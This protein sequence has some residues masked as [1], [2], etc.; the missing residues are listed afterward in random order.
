MRRVGAAQ[1]ELLRGSVVPDAWVAE[2]DA[3]F[4]SRPAIPP[5]LAFA[6]GLWAGCA[7]A[8]LRARLLSIAVCIAL[9]VGGIATCLCCLYMLLR[10]RRRLLAL[11]LMAGLL[12]GGVLGFAQGVRLHQA[13]QVALGSQGQMHITA[14]SDGV[15]GEFGVSCTAHVQVEGSGRSFTA[16]QSC[17]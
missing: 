7:S 1:G 14:L 13:Q 17:G 12:C 16:E 4:P 6:L 9:C 3:P 10:R 2:D 11:V 5:V 8:L 15:Q